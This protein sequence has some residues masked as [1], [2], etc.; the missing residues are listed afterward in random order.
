MHT[1]STQR[2]NSKTPSRSH[3]SE[4]SRSG[5]H[6]SGS[7]KTPSELQ[8]NR[9]P[10]GNETSHFKDGH[11]RDEVDSHHTNQSKGKNDNNHRG[12]R[13]SPTQTG[14]QPLHPNQRSGKEHVPHSKPSEKTQST[15]FDRLGKHT[16]QKDQ[17]D[18][19]ADRRRTVP[20]EGRDNLTY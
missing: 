9:A 13:D 8:H 10:R 7:K 6:K 11:G 12:G 14:R 16:A 4:T 3:R 18:I 15:M 19:I 20:V 5:S 17:R 1:T 2:G